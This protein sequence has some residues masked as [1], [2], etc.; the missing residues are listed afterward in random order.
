M[1]EASTSNSNDE[2]I[3]SLASTDL[4]KG[5]Y[6]GGFKTW[7]CAVDL[8]TLL[9][10]P[11]ITNAV[12]SD[13]S[14]PLHVIELGA[15]SAIP[16]LAVLQ[17]ALSR[18]TAN[19]PL[20]FTLAD[21]NLDVLKLCTAPN[22]Y[23]NHHLHTSQSPSDITNGTDFEV[24]LEPLAASV[25]SLPNDLAA[26]SL[27][28]NFVSGAWGSSFFSLLKPLLA[29]N[30]SGQAPSVLLLASETIYSPTTMPEFVGTMMS[31]LS[32]GA[33]NSRALVAAKKVYF[34]VG[35]GVADFEAEVID[36]GGKVKTIWESG[37]G[38]GVGRVIIEVTLS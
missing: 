8:A 34:G 26:S 32:L 9:F 5:R 15:G 23:L 22:L 2:L 24:D 30:P 28:V 17:Q 27:S 7:E 6:E 14:N 18:Q 12:A 10:D 35:G 38:A 21:Y 37:H 36:R 3:D 13:P 11:T 20:T 4:S 33:T 1:A 19:P 31:L 16:S 25:A 29:P